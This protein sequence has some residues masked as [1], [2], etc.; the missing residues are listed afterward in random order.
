MTPLRALPL[1]LLVLTVAGCDRPQGTPSAASASANVAPPALRAPAPPPPTEAPVIGVP[2]CDEYFKLAFKCTAKLDED[3]RAKT[4]ASILANVAG[5]KAL[6]AT[7]QNRA[8]LVKQ[9]TGVFEALKTSP[10]CR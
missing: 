1:A 3:I 5:W 2:E 6:A 9:C 4:E 10:T 8:E 7:P